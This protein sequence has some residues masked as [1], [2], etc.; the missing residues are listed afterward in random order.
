MNRQIG[1]IHYKTGSTDGV[2]L[3]IGK[4]KRVFEEAGHTVHLCSGLHEHEGEQRVTTIDELNYHSKAAV[5]LYRGTFVSLN[6]YRDDRKAYEADFTAQS[7]RLTQ[8]LS[9]WIQEHGI[10]VLCVENIW[11]VGLHPAA[12]EALQKI[13]TIHDLKVLAHHHDFYWEKVTPLALTCNKAMEAADTLFPPHSAEYSHVVI[14]SL[15]QS[16]L[17]K[18]KGIASTVVPNVFDFSDPAESTEGFAADSFNSDFRKNIGIDEEAII[19]LQ[20][21]RIIPRKGIELAVDTVSAMNALLSSYI[22]STMYDGR[23]ISD[24]TEI[25]LV[26]AGYSEDDD[27]G[28]YLNQLKT[29]AEEQGVRMLHIQDRI[30]SHRTEGKEKRYSL[31]DAYARADI[32]SYPSYWEGWGNQLLEALKAKL[33]VILYE[34][35]VYRSDI[36]PVG[37]DVISLGA[38]M[39]RKEDGFITVDDKT[40]LNAALEALNTLT[41]KEKYEKMVEHNFLQGRKHFSL[42]A[43][44]GYLAPLMEEW[45]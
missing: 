19:V 2:S 24:E 40:C 3:E 14:N 25:V 45:E 22:G 13:V 31:W 15:A 29:Y 32:V 11:S 28:R 42:E 39:S 43:L 9:S 38:E 41:N 36:A 7:T 27:T 37:L 10:T 21:T 20:A 8:S 5:R 1:I 16:S 26:L 18:R 44:R 4:W 12:A 30:D 35:P 33:P 34:Y 17:M 23:R 6:A